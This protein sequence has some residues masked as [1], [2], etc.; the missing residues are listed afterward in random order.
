MVDTIFSNVSFTGASHL[1]CCVLWVKCLQT[2]STV[3]SSPSQILP[4]LQ[5][6]TASIACRRTNDFLWY[7]IASQ[8]SS[9]AAS[10]KR[11]PMFSS[12]SHPK[13]GTT[14]ATCMHT[15]SEAVLV[16]HAATYSV[17]V[18]RVYHGPTQT[19]QDGVQTSCDLGVVLRMV[20]SAPSL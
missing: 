11:Q 18:I 8:Q 20:G 16:G 4:A 2:P 9:M 14:N 6:N 3:L 1:T 10:D 19:G 15:S 12:L 13:G 7:G 5:A 17:H